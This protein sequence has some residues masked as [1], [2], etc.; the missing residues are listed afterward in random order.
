MIGYDRLDSSF[1]VRL[2]GFPATL[3]HGDTLVLDRWR[4]LSRRLPLTANGE[5]LLDV[6]CGTGAFTIGAAR[7]GYQATGVSW[8]ER[9]QRVAETRALACKAADARFVTGDVRQ[10]D[11]MPELQDD[12][13]VIICLE[14]VEH[15]INDE[16]LFRDMAA[17]L[18]PGGRL[19]LTTPNYYYHPISQ[20]DRGPFLT[21]ET[22]WH[23]RRGYTP[24]MLQE[25]CERT[26]LVCHEVTYC[27]GYLSQKMTKVWRTSG[28]M[29]GGSGVRWVLTLPLRVVPAILPDS[30]F[31]QLINWPFFSICLEA[32]RPRFN[33]VAARGKD[34]DGS[35]S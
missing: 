25:L 22:G 29:P 4:W 19:L 7:L 16:K 9:N 1:L 31:T 34:Q 23:V 13:D 17:R 6:G 8:D 3:L 27:G 30:R 33:S 14:C 32:Y 2:F 26:G 18:K 15:V 10:L 11:N 24:P 20:S 21:E 28:F 5:S 35:A 12:Y